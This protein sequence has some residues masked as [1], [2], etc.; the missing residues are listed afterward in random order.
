MTVVLMLMKLFAKFGSNSAPVTVTELAIVP[1]S[2]GLTT[3]CLLAEPPGGML[4]RAHMTRATPK[5]QLPPVAKSACTVGE[6]S[7]KTRTLVAVPDPPFL[8]TMV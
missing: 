7:S 8:T 4:P 5:L 3:I 1:A 2:L 6:K